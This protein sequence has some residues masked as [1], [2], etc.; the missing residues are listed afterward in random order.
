MPFLTE[1]Q[2]QDVVFAEA[3]FSKPDG[4]GVLFTNGTG[5]GK[6][7]TGLGV[8]YR[9]FHS[10]KRSILIVA[11]KQPIVD[12]W[13]KAGSQYFNLPIKRLEGMTDNGG[14]GIVVTTYANLAG[15]QSLVERNWDM[16]VMD[17]AHYLSSD[18]AGSDTNALKMT[19]AIG[20]MSGSAYARVDALHPE[21]I[22]RIREIHGEIKAL[23]G[24]EN[25][26]YRVNALQDELEQ[27]DQRRSKLIGEEKDRLAKLPSEHRPRG[28]FLSA[29]P[30]AYEKSVTWANGFLFDWG[31]DDGF[32]G[33]NSGNAYDRFMMQH[34]GYRMR[35]G[36]LTEPEAEVDR[37]LMQRTFNAWLKREGVL[38]SRA[39]DSDFDYDRRFVLT[40]SAIGRRVDDAIE[41]LREHG[42][43]SDEMA[44][45]Y[46]TLIGDNFDYHA[47]MYFLE[48]IKAREAIPQI[49]AHL[50]MGRNVVVMHDFKQGGARN[51]FRITP[52]DEI[53]HAYDQFKAEF[54]DL[55]RAFSSIPSP[56][57]LLSRE[58]PDAL[59]YNGSVS[60]KRRVEQQ[61]LFNSDTEGTPRLIIAQGDAMREGVSI[62]DTTG[63]HPR[64]MIHLGMPVKPT[65]AIQQ[66]GRIYRTGQKSN[67]MFRYL[68]IGTSWE[69]TA[70]ASKIATRASAAE[71]LAMG[72]EARGLKAAFIQAYEEAGDYAPG[73]E[74]EG[75]GGKAF[76]RTL[77]N[78]LTPWDMAK[79]MYF[80]NQK[81][82][83]GRGSKGRAQEDY[84][85]TPEPVGLKMVQLADIRGGDAVLEP[86]AGH[87][88]IA[89]WFPENS[90][91]RAIELTNE[92]SSKLALHFGGDLITGRFE[93]HHVVNKYNAIVMNPPFGHGGK[94]AA[95]HVAKA[96]THLR[97]GG[98][99]VALIPTGPAA[100]KRFNEL[101]YGD[102]ANPAIHKI[103]EIAMPGVTFERAGTSVATK[104]LVLEKQANQ[105]LAAQLPS[106]SRDYTGITST[107]ELFDRMENLELEPR[108]TE[109]TAEQQYQQRA[110]QQKE[111]DR[112]QQGKDAELIATSPWEVV[113]HTTMKGKVI[114]G[115]IRTDLT[116]EQAE[117]IDPYTFKKGDGFFIRE[118][119]IPAMLAG[120]DHLFNTIEEIQEYFEYVHLESQEIKFIQTTTAI[121]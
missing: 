57:E 105:E 59:V 52:K 21:I 49:R 13:V 29:T 38:S 62:H 100:D 53:A 113:K 72:E 115:V 76:D 77:A 79:S 120:F 94:L 83:K 73:H 71:N 24:D 91:S 68:T 111:R 41:W 4:T 36:K 39:L 110:E 86:S 75:T 54:G 70:F 96:I 15:N 81:L 50:E 84:F 42:R 102:D 34:F 121:K 118:K 119:H 47:R 90:T 3:R 67:A 109:L 97:D 85:A 95:E 35:Y 66:E 78:N 117:A 46:D 26:Q 69:R 116:I 17:E 108:K 25:R 6:T 14:D 64:V 23:S 112:E 19:R 106:V 55:I 7:F 80:A 82:G 51:P 99:I 30:F 18:Q 27:L 114:S 104:I 98:R 48:A 103:A 32:V 87:G 61:E 28:V 10:G 11:P 22:R 107:K 12:A 92:L 45:L 31:E 65:A 8:I 16:L 93:D 89:R 37:G 2:A 74:G 56:I 88:A 60:A 9:A 63:Q 1:G 40:E 5:T 33:Y 43:E 101:L 20:Q 44:Q 58:F